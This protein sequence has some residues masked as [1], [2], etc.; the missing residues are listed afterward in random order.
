MILGYKGII[1]MKHTTPEEPYVNGLH[2]DTDSYLR[3]IVNDGIYSIFGEAGHYLMNQVV[4]SNPDKYKYALSFNN[5]KVQSIRM[6]MDNILNLHL[7]LYAVTVRVLALR[8]GNVITMSSIS[9]W[10]YKNKYTDN[11]DYFRFTIKEGGFNHHI[12]EYDLAPYLRIPH[13]LVCVN[14]V[15]ER[16][17]RGLLTFEK[18][19][20]V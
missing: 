20:S 16:L 5:N 18:Q 8:R 7:E 14:G 15:Y 17:I 6:Y 3:T 9:R 10:L 19:H 11:V 1:T 12:L 13:R 2:P 4:Y